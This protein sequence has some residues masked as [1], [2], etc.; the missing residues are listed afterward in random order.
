MRVAAVWRYGVAAALVSALAAPGCA[1]DD[2][3]A[4]AGREL[5]V[6]DFRFEPADLSVKGGLQVTLTV[7]NRGGVVHNLS[8][9]SIPVDLD[10]AAGRR[11][12]LIFVPPNAPGDIEFF[13][14]F[15]VDRGMKGTFRLQA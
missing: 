5:T 8:I 12:T 4:V 2:D 7:V 13:C 3:G 10:V 6:Q 15:H 11:E 14:K 9:P 1:A